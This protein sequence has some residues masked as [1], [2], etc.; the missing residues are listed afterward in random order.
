MKC[1]SACIS[2]QAVERT[3]LNGWF[4]TRDKEVEDVRWVVFGNSVC[5]ERASLAIDL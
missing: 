3:I 2:R 4:S 1:S 5:F